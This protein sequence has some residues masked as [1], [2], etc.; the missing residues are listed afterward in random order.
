MT[1]SHKYNKLRYSGLPK[2]PSDQFQIPIVWG[3]STLAVA[4]MKQ[5]F[6]IYFIFSRATL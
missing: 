6:S 2:P 5:H 1:Q 3:A 4:S